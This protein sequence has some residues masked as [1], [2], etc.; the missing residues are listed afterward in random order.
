[1]AV[2]IEKDRIG[3]VFEIVRERR[4][5]D[6]VQQACQSF[7][8]FASAEPFR[9]ARAEEIDT[10]TSFYR[11]PL[12][13]EDFPDIDFS[14]PLQADRAPGGVMSQPPSSG[15]ASSRSRWRSPVRTSRGWRR[16]SRRPSCS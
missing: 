10:E 6:D 15:S 8:E 2:S 16:S 14:R 5:R 1:M 9:S 7:I 3:S 12:R 4:T 13:R 11:R